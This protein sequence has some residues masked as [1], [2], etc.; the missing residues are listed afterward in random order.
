MK[1]LLLTLMASL[2][3]SFALPTTANAEITAADLDG[4]YYGAY[5]VGMADAERS[6]ATDQFSGTFE[7]R[8]SQLYMTNFLECVD[9]PVTI[10][11]NNLTLSCSE[12]DAVIS[13]LVNPQISVERSMNRW[14]IDNPYYAY[15]GEAHQRYGSYYGYKRADVEYGE[16]RNSVQL[17][18]SDNLGSSEADRM[19][20]VS[21]L[22]SSSYKYR[23]ATDQYI[24]AEYKVGGIYNTYGT[25]DGMRVYVFEANGIAKQTNTDGSVTTYGIGVDMSPGEPEKVIFKNIFNKGVSFHNDYDNNGAS[26]WRTILSWVEGTIDY[27]NNTITIPE[28]TVGGYV[29]RQNGLEQ[30][31]WYFYVADRW[32]Y[33]DEYCADWYMVSSRKPDVYNYYIN[34]SDDNDLVG[35][36]TYKDLD[37]YTESD[38]HWSQKHGGQLRTLHKLNFEFEDITLWE[39]DR[40]N[41]RAN[42]IATSQTVFETP[43]DFE[44]THDAQL[45]LDWFAQ[46]KDKIGLGGSIV[47]RVNNRYVES[48]DLYIMPG[49]HTSIQDV[50]I[51]THH[52]IGIEGAE[53]IASGLRPSISTYSEGDDK[54][55]VITFGDVV[56]DRPVPY[57]PNRDYTLYLKANYNNDLH[58]SYHAMTLTANIPTGIIDLEDYN[59][60]LKVRAVEGGILVEGCD[61]EVEVF[62]VAGQGIF[63][64]HA[65]G[66]I[67]LDCGLYIV[68][69]GNRTWK[70]NVK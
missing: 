23:L 61:G 28:Q 62:S 67:S 51:N 36:V 26:N 47:S 25:W 39:W 10:E 49:S 11:G 30:D 59:P 7:L 17:T 58:P 8:G 13:G 15:N 5:M 29:K 60:A 3:I 31:T 52:D 9:M 69:A 22:E 43:L 44:Y 48:Y 1:K 16:S 20:D 66:A 68:R 50:D 37:H 42:K 24:H 56:V 57:N 19:T 53:L 70:V 45:Q 27:D 14:I 2:A 41:G 55:S 34:G 38:N 12:Y 33:L 63:A 40:T 6:S 65:D 21:R 18:F 35:R 46:D 32:G 4:L 64:G 54:D